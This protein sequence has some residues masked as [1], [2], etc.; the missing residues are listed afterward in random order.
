MSFD[1]TNAAMSSQPAMSLDRTERAGR[2]FVDV[3]SE[4]IYPVIKD[5]YA[6]LVGKSPTRKTARMQVKA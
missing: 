1:R 3:W 6:M 5:D 2:S 4:K